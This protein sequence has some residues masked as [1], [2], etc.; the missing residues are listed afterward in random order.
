MKAIIDADVLANLLRGQYTCYWC[1]DIADIEHISAH[2]DN[3]LK[4]VNWLREHVEQAGRTTLPVY[5]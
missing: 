1:G 5:G 3:C 2:V 4:E